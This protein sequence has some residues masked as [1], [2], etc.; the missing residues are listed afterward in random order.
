MHEIVDVNEPAVATTAV[1]AYK[2]I[3]SF[4]DDKKLLVRSR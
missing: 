4:L 3:S 1:F 2:Q